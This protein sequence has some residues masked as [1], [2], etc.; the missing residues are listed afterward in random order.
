M[1]ERVAAGGHHYKDAVRKAVFLGS[2]IVTNSEW[3]NLQ[4]CEMHDAAGSADLGSGHSNG[5]RYI[6]ESHG[7]LDALGVDVQSP[8]CD[9]VSEALGVREVLCL[10]ALIPLVKGV[11]ALLAHRLIPLPQRSIKSDEAHSIVVSKKNKA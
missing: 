9:C 3:A 6:E 7:R 10:K 2:P 11:V 8:L 5:L 4:A 1:A